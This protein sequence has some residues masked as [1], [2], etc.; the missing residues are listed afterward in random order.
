MLPLV[1]QT[2]LGLYAI[3]VTATTVWFCFLYLKEAEGLGAAWVV[4]LMTPFFWMIAV[5]FSVGIAALALLV[6]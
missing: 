6:G 3:G 5:C 1:W 4:L 2:A